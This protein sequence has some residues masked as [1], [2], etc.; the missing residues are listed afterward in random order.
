[1][2]AVEIYSHAL[3]NQLQLEENSSN[4]NDYA[5]DIIS[6]LGMNNLCPL[7]GH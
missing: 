7:G 1:V 4:M 6:I 5:S 3:Q 2:I